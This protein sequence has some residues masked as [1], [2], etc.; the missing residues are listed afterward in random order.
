MI[1]ETPPRIP[2]KIDISLPVNTLDLAVQDPCC[3]NLHPFVQLID[4]CGRYSILDDYYTVSVHTGHG[5]EEVDIGDIAR[6]S[7]GISKLDGGNGV[8]L[9]RHLE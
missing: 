2:R 6:V 3:I 8:V 9:G 4:H 5:V 7:L 1:S